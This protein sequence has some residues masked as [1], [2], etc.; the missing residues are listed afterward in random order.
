[1]YFDLDKNKKKK[2]KNLEKM[3]NLRFNY[4]LTSFQKL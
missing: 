2:T 4:H 3:Q 1:M